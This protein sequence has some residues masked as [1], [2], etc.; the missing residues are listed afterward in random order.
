MIPLKGRTHRSGSD[1][2]LQSRA[3]KPRITREGLDTVD[4]KAA[5]INASE[6]RAINVG[7]PTRMK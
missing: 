6:T 2:G 4:E 1:R 3:E 5:T 7:F